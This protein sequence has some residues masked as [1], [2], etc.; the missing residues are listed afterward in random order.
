MMGQFEF[1]YV[2]NDWAKIKEKKLTERE[3]YKRRRS[4]TAV[5]GVE[6]KIPPGEG[7]AEI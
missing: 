7:D 1:L 4:V 3:Y 2:E 5:K 6:C